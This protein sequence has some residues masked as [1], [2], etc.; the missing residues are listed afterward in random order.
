LLA[1]KT[2]PTI[3]DFLCTVQQPLAVNLFREAAEQLNTV[4]DTLL[5]NCMNDMI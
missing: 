4:R 3:D 2:I 1:E 5:Y